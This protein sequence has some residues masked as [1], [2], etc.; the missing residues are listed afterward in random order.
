[1]NLKALHERIL[2]EYE[3]FFKQINIQ[4]LE[5]YS[6][7]NLLLNEFSRNENS[8]KMI[9]DNSNYKILAISDNIEALTGYTKKDF[10][11]ANVLLYFKALDFDHLL[12]PYLLSKWTNKML[13]YI[14]TLN[15]IDYSTL[16]VT[17]CGIKMKRKNGEKARTLQR[18]IPLEISPSGHVDICIAT[19][20][21]IIHLL[22]SDFFWVRIACEGDVPYRFF[23]SSVDKKTHYNDIISEREKDI[24]QLISKGLESKE[25]AQELFISINTVDNHRRNAI[26]RTGARD[27]TALIQICKMCG[28]L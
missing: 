17:V 10:F 8:L 16:H 27:T 24:L 5:E 14:G 25:I 3:P 6:K 22:K 20:E 23:Y 12:A 26:A 21:D 15:N 7:M 13:H 2:E 9:F 28:I 18:Y 19:G 4:K 1:M 11:K